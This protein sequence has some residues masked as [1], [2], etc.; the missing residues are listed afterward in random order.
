MTGIWPEYRRLPPDCAMPG[1]TLDRAAPGTPCLGHESRTKHPIR[2]RYPRDTPVAGAFV[3]AARLLRRCR[4]RHRLGRTAP[5]ALRR[6]G[7][8]APR[9]RPQPLCG[10]EPEG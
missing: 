1:P 7:L 6:A 2:H 9:D 5:E 3:L 4:A 8:R 10:G